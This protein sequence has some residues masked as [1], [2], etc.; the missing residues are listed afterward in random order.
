M[1]TTLAALA[2]VA[3]GYILA[4]LLFDRLR[5]RYGYVG[6]AE[7]VLIGFILGP[8]VTG[9]LGTAQMQDLTPIVS[10][11]LGWMGMLLGTY[12]RLPMFALLPA[13]H[14]QIA[15]TEA[16]TT[17]GAVLAAMLAIFR[18]IAC[19]C[20][21]G[22]FHDEAAGGGPHRPSRWRRASRFGS[23]GA[24]PRHPVHPGGAGT[25]GAGIA[26]G[27]GAALERVA[28]LPERAGGGR[29]WFS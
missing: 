14:L 19:W 23:E 8:R 4:Y 7:Y 17:F 12:F 16:L 11:A 29:R 24:S 18:Y 3:V 20:A 22:S 2:V 25:R 10:L 21:G 28:P 9:L 6:G 1:Q 26:V 5:D 27:R 13:T 15:F